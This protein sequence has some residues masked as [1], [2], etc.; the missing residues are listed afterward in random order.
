MNSKIP[1]TTNNAEKSGIGLQNVQRRLELSYPN[2]HKIQIQD[3]ADAYAVQL[4]LTLS[5]RYL[6]E[7]S[8]VPLAVAAR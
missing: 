1:V 6:Q 8:E 7:E 3:T 4:T 5:D 2:R